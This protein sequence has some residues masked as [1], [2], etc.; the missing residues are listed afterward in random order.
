[1]LVRKYETVCLFV[2]L[3]KKFKKIPS[4][5]LHKTLTLPSGQAPPPL[6]DMSTKNV[7]FILEMIKINSTLLKEI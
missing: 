3:N 6:A 4:I 2:F 1:M 5:I 7:N